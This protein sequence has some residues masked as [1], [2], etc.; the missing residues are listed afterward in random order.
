MSNWWSPLGRRLEVVRDVYRRGDALLFAQSF[1]VASVMPLLFR[2][3]LPRLDAL[4][5]WATARAPRD[6]ARSPE[7]VATTVLDMLRT[8]RP[9]VR[10]GCLTRGGT[11]YYF[12]RRSG[13]DVALHFGMGRVPGGDGFE[14]HCWLVRD[15][16]PFLEPGD[17][18]HDYVFMYAFGKRA[19]AEAVA[20]FEG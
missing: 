2:L 20:A 7:A 9:L 16:E 17:P 5:E 1:C 8:A 12:L 11:L 15:G 6:A 10:R 3:P 14:G 4:L 13:V 19:A 18:R